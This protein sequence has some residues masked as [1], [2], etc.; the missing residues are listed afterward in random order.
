MRPTIP[1]TVQ[2]NSGP[3]ILSFEGKTFVFRRNTTDDQRG[4]WFC[5]QRWEQLPPNSVIPLE[6]GKDLTALARAR[7]IIEAHDYALHPK[8]EEKKPSVRIPKEEKPH[9]SGGMLKAGKGGAIN[10]LSESR[11]VVGIAPPKKHFP[12]LKLRAQ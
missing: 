2:G 5:M 1:A 3:P 10:P 8:K 6:F 12:M 4:E 11:P 7:G 9:L